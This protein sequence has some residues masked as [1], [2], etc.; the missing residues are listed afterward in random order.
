MDSDGNGLR[1]IY[2]KASEYGGFSWFP[3]GKKLLFIRNESVMEVEDNR[4][5]KSR[6]LTLADAVNL[7]PLRVR[8]SP[9]GNQ[10]A[11]KSSLRHTAN[12]NEYDLSVFQKDGSGRKSIY[13]GKKA[14]ELA[15]WSPDSKVIYFTIADTIIEG[16]AIS[17]NLKKSRIEKPEFVQVAAIFGRNVL[18]SPDE[19]KIF[20]LENLPQLPD[21]D[22]DYND[23][24]LMVS[25][26]PKGK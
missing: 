22:A 17:V 3:D 20:W 18:V 24:G 8:L 4:E 9:D 26:M 14:A 13:Q 19:R 16:D 6:T 12:G 23:S 15:G 10:I 25:E 1:Y 7:E 5:P 21:Q 11:I 2:P